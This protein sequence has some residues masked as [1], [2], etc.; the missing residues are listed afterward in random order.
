M[1]FTHVNI[2]VYIDSTADTSADGIGSVRA[3]RVGRRTWMLVADSGQCQPLKYLKKNR[4]TAPTMLGRIEDVDRNGPPDNPE[5]FKWLDAHRYR[6][7]RL[8]EYKVHHPQ[9]CRAYGFQTG[10]GLVIVRIEDKTE[11]NRQFNETMKS[12]KTMI[13]QFLDGGERYV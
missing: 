10:R 1:P 8:C 9:A 5:L 2:F 7:L 12:I 11:S 13:D 4:E 6:G 3:E